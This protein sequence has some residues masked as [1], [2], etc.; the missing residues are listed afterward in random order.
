[1]KKS[2]LKSKG[3]IVIYIIV[4]I[5]A[6]LLILGRKSVHAEVT[7]DAKPQK[8]WQVLTNTS[9]YSEWNTV[10]AI[11]EGS[12][13]KGETVKYNFTDIEGK[14]S[15]I[16][17]K[18][19]EKTENQLLNQKGGMP[20]ILT[21]DHRYSLAEVEGKTKLVIHEDYRG[22]MVPFWSPKKVQLSYEKLVEKIKS[23]AESLN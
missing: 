20:L 4:G 11:E 22:I 15:V 12:V 6:L 5:V 21:Y 13:T 19:I 7:I 17:A 23:R 9:K 3:L 10:M 8:V 18:V 2:I 14:S 1:V 16:P